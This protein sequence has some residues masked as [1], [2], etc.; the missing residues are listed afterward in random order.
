MNDAA[1]CLRLL[2]DQK[3][4][5]KSLSS[6]VEGRLE[7]GGLKSELADFL[8]AHG[9]NIYEM[10]K[11]AIILMQAEEPFAT[12]LLARTALESAFNL[13]ASMEDRQ[14]GPQRIVC[15]LEDLAKKMVFVAGPRQIGKTT[16]ARGISGTHFK[17]AAAKHGC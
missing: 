8:W 6:E 14:F 5:L 11:A 16:L 2:E 7:Q 13:V 4:L 3:E 9:L 15:E 1:E 17:V 12:A 10:A